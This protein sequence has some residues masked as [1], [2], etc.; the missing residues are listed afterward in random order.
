MVVVFQA[1]ELSRC[2]SW[3]LGADGASRAGLSWDRGNFRHKGRCVAVLWSFKKSV[4]ITQKYISFCWVVVAQKNFSASL[5]ALPTRWL[6]LHQ[7][8]GGDRVRT[9]GQGWPKGCAMSYEGVL[10]SKNWG[11]RR[12]EGCYM[13]GIFFPSNYCWMVACQWEAVN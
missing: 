12:R 2:L 7:E 11:E 3:L 5:V 13:D 9:A 6:G 4:V 1:L 8:L 10:S